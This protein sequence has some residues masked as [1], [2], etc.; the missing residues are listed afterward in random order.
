M[1]GYT[2]SVLSLNRN[3]FGNDVTLKISLSPPYFNTTISLLSLEEYL[4]VISQSS[5]SG[6]IFTLNLLIKKEITNEPVIKLGFT[7]IA[8][9]G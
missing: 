2:V 1:I 9:T 8:P 3:P 6:T 5:S 4:D 7:N